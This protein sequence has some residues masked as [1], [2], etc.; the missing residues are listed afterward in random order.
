MNNDTPDERD[1]SDDES[2]RY[3]RRKRRRQTATNPNEDPRRQASE[4]S[5]RPDEVFTKRNFPNKKKDAPVFGP[6]VGSKRRRVEQTKKDPDFK[7]PEPNRKIP[8]DTMSEL[9]EDEQVAAT[10]MTMGDH[11]FGA[12]CLPP[13]RRERLLRDYEAKMGGEETD[14]DEEQ[15]T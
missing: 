2:E 3:C 5:A 6:R 14:D 10:L 11:G 7:S 12:W 4:E 8:L 13:D 9:S 15:S 1:S